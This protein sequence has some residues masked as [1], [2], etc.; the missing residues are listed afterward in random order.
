MIVK[1]TTDNID[2]YIDVLIDFYALSRLGFLKLNRGNAKKRLTAHLSM[3]GNVVLLAENNTQQV[4]GILWGAITKHPL[5][6][7]RMSTIHAWYVL[8]PYRGSIHGVRL[9]AKF[10]G[11][12]R[13]SNSIEISFSDDGAP[14]PEANSI[15]YRLGFSF[16]GSRRLLVLG[17]SDL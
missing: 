17:M 15:L 4:V 3:Q 9:F 6:P 10:L 16:E 7:L 1:V 5:A 11:L 14:P 13:F 2:K 8:E 12:S